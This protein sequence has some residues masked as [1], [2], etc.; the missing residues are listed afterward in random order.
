MDTTL[1]SDRM[2]NRRTESPPCFELAALT[3]TPTPTISNNFFRK[4]EIRSLWGN[5]S[6]LFPNGRFCRNVMIYT[7]FYLLV[8]LRLNQTQPIF[9]TRQP[10]LNPMRETIICQQKHTMEF[11]L[12]TIFANT[13]YGFAT[14]KQAVLASLFE[15]RTGSY[16]H[17]R[18][19]PGSY[20]YVRLR[21]RAS[22][23]LLA[24]LKS[25]GQYHSSERM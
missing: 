9:K 5:G 11:R 21:D 12:Y 19:Q 25:K 17:S 1:R 3:I 14:R 10:L 6:F 8:F 22:H 7:M 18:H 23:A 20:V 2:R 15:S 24:D 16:W 13:Q 4:S